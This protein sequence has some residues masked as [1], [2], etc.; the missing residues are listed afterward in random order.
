MR[1]LI[2]EAKV[3]PGMRDR[4]IEAITDDA[5]HSMADEPGCSRFDVLQDADDPDTFYLYEIYADDAAIDAHFE[6]P[7]FL[8]LAD[9]L[10]ELV[11]GELQRRV[12]TPI[13]PTTA[14]WR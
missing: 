5:T 9:A 4:F 11:E 10:P 7:H 14:N 3:K 1:A 2:V 6:T 8:R 12:A 13:H